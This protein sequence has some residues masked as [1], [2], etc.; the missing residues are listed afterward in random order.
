MSLLPNR[1]R[2]AC[3]PAGSA[4]TFEGRPTD[5]SLPGPDEETNVA[6]LSGTIVEE[7]LEDKSRDGDPVTVLL[8]SFDAPDEKA[9]QAV[10]VCEVEI[11][12]EIANLQ[13]KQLRAGKRLVVLG[14]LT[15]A[16]G[17]WAKAIATGRSSRTQG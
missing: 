8:M 7:P 11:P 16:G 1:L 4:S 2:Q 5:L 9:R 13:R 3:R 12:E 15:G 10:A 6:L 14:Q 17:L